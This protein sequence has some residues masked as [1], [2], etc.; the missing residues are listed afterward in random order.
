MRSSIGFI[1][2]VGMIGAAGHTADGRLGEMA[3]MTPSSG[4]TQV[5][6]ATGI[7]EPFN[8]KRRRDNW[9]AKLRVEGNLSNITYQSSTA[10]PGGTTGW[11]SHPGP[12]FVTVTAGAVT[13]YNAEDPGCAPRVFTVGQG[14]IEEETVHILRNEGTLDARWTSANIRPIDQPARFDAPDPATCP[15]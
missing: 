2:L 9:Q 1:V 4:I 11:H 3:A 8:L 6:V 14:F 7:F 15:F 13:V 12:V 10:I 5:L